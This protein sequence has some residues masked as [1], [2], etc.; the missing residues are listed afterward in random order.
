MQIRISDKL[1]KRATERAL[2]GRPGQMKLTHL[3]TWLLERYADGR[4]VLDDE[5]A[6]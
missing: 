3:V 4:L 1:A 5:A 2:D 6:S